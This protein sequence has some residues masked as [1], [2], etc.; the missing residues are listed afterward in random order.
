[1]KFQFNI[2]YCS[3]M[4]NNKE[5]QLDKGKRLQKAYPGLSPVTLPHFAVGE[6]WWESGGTEDIGGI[7]I[8]WDTKLLCLVNFDSMIRWS[9]KTWQAPPR[10]RNSFICEVDYLALLFLYKSVHPHNNSQAR[11][12]DEWLGIVL[13]GLWY[14]YTI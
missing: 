12:S 7:I 2:L 4:T 3:I 9:K 11:R 14:W 6:S 1:M 10:H 13:N 5:I 8:V